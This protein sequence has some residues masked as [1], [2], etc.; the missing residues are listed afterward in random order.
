[1]NEKKKEREGETE[2]IGKG[3]NEKALEGGGGEV[4]K[5]NIGSPSSSFSPQPYLAF[6][7]FNKNMS[8]FPLHEFRVFVTGFFFFFFFFF[9]DLSGY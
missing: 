7:T 5:D 3:G 8:F 1:M 6:S 2:G 9:L 4:K